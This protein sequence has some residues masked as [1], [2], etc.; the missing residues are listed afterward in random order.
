MIDIGA[1]EHQ[2]SI[3]V[4]NANG[5]GPG[6]LADAVDGDDDGTPIDFDSTLSGEAITLTPGPLNIQSNI[7]ITG[8]GANNLTI[9]GGNQYQIFAVPSGV[10]ATIT[11]LTLANGMA[12]LGGAISNAGNLT[13]TQVALINNVAQGNYVRVD[14]AGGAIFNAPLASLT[15][16][17]RHVR[18][19]F[20]QGV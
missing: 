15:H 12:Q 5:S 17:C 16:Q 6:S 10:T 7:T 18:Q 9:S 13:L 2:P 11:G 4:T 14:A 20:R 3:L 19:R 8:P 1:F